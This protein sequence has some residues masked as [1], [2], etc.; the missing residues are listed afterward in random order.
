M[1]PKPEF[2]KAAVE[3]VAVPV[4]RKRARKAKA[5]TEP[6]KMRAP[7]LTLLRWAEE[8]GEGYL[9]AVRAAP[10]E[11][12]R[13]LRDHYRDPHPDNFND[14][15]LAAQRALEDAKEH[16]AIM[17]ARYEERVAVLARL[18]AF[19]AARDLAAGKQA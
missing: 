9:E 3:I 1:E 5:A 8:H 14:D 18:D 7:R 2:E 4:K 10:P 15:L 19:K 12:V 16:K 11:L 13:D 17:A 6:K